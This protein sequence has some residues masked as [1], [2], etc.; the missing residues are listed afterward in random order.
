MARRRQI[1]VCW[2]SLD[3]DAKVAVA[4]AFNDSH[5][6]NIS[7][8][9]ASGPLNRFAFHLSTASSAENLGSGA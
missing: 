2:K 6:C 4:G 7:G 9:V 8:N 1:G 5:A 3:I